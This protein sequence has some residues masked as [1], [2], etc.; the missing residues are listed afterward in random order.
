MSLDAKKRAFVAGY[1]KSGGSIAA[2]IRAQESEK[3]EDTLSEEKKP[4]SDEING[5]I[6]D[7]LLNHESRDS[8]SGLTGRQEKFAYEYLLDQNAAAASIRAGYST[9]GASVNAHRLMRMPAVVKKI[10][11]LRESTDKANIMKAES[12]LTE[13]SHVASSDIRELFDSEGQLK[14]TA[15]LPTKT[16]RAVKSVKIL[17]RNG[18]PD[19][20]G[21]TTQEFVHE[22]TFWDKIAALDKLAKY[23]GILADR[24]VDDPV[25]LTEAESK[26]ALRRQILREL[27]NLATPIAPTILQDG[28]EA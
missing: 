20:N 11:E 17:V 5:E 2:G 22:I 13:L 1:I 23:H 12:V 10:S 15:E 28:S 24:P 25:A 14:R 6:S 7:I 21:K 16:A 19:E 3:I 4:D 18:P 9:K 27:G 26:K 8:V